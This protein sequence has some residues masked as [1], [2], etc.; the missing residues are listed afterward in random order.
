M[1]SEIAPPTSRLSDNFTSEQETCNAS[2]QQSKNTSISQQ[3]S[4]NS[5][6]L[7]RQSF[8]SRDLSKSVIDIICMH[9]WR[10]W[11]KQQYWSYIQ[12]WMRFALKNML[13]PYH[14]L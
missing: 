4:L 10:D 12:K 11:I 14:H 6:Q 3:T 8:E 1:A 5:L 2:F 7:V 13:V 9:S